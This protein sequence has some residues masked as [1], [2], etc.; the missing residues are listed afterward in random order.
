MAIRVGI[1][2]ACRADHRA[3]CATT[4]GTLLWSNVRFQ[5]RAEELEN[6]WRR[7]PD[8]ETDVT[9][10]M[11][12]TRNAWVP[13]AAWFRRHGAKVV[14]V[15]PEQSSDLRA[16]YNK[17]AKTDRLDA[18]LLAR[19]PSLHPEGIHHERGIGPAQPLRRTVKIRS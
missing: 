11:E 6:I 7:I 9:I 10:V 19:L 12:P 2:I 17:H 8:G 18:E 16:Y 13:L 3:A 14:L 4:D 5:T 15:P 1:D